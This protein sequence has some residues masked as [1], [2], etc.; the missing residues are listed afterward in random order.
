MGAATSNLLLI[1]GYVGITC[2][3]AAWFDAAQS[4]MEEQHMSLSARERQALHSIEHGLAEADPDLVAKLASLSHLMTGEYTPVVERSRPSW[5]LRVIG[6]LACWLRSYGRVRCGALPRRA[7]AILA[8]W[9]V[10]SCALIA[11]AATLSPVTARGPCSALSVT[12]ASRS[13]ASPAQPG[14]R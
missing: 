2:G 6:T 11:T 3:E 12:C 14:A 8:F 4:R 13:P 5:P 7:P 9:L 1:A 10:I